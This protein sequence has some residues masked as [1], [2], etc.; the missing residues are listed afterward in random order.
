MRFREFIDTQGDINIDGFWWNLPMTMF[1]HDCVGVAVDVDKLDKLWRECDPSNY[2]P[3]KGTKNTIGDRYKRHQQFIKGARSYDMPIVGLA[4]ETWDHKPLDPPRDG[5]HRIAVFRD[6]GW[7][8]IGVGVDW[9]KA[10]I[11]DAMIGVP[12]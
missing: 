6:A 2:I 5:R 3:P 4:T 8:K 10:K 11:L 7:K 12:K 1:A 9:S